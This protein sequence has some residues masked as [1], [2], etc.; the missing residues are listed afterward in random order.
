MAVN[1]LDSPKRAEHLAAVLVGQHL[2]GERQ[3]R[4]LAAVDLHEAGESGDI[5]AEALNEAGDLAAVDLHEASDAG[6]PAAEAMQESGDLAA[7]D[8][9]EA[10]EA[11]VHA[12]RALLLVVSAPF[13][14]RST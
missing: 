1:Q 11:R 8:L 2:L 4:E 14:D 6:D 12:V 9:H 13:L 3:Y 5:A 10:G 7:V